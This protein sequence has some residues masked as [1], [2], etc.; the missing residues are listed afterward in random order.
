MIYVYPMRGESASG[1]GAV[2]AKVSEC[3]ERWVVVVG[4]MR[5]TIMICTH[6][7]CRV[8]PLPPLPLPAH[9]CTTLTSSVMYE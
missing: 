4:F 3:R 9:T 1:G 6:Q 2:R 7:M 5:S 8:P